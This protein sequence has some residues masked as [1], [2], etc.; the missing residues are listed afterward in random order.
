M[1]GTAEGKFAPSSNFV[2]SGSRSVAI[3]FK[4]RHSAHGMQECQRGN[5]VDE[6]S[7]LIFRDST[8]RMIPDF[9]KPA[10]ADSRGLGKKLS[11]EPYPSSAAP[12]P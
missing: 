8:R 9:E 12:S 4:G 2:D 6:P 3:R 1:V 10:G 7:L 11:R 5:L